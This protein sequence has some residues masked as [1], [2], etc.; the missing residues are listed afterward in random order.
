MAGLLRA[1]TAMFASIKCGLE[2][3]KPAGCHTAQED[4]TSTAASQS[5]SE[6]PSLPFGYVDAGSLSQSPV[7]SPTTPGVFNSLRTPPQLTE[8]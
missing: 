8:N 2:Q 3:T 6:L 1:S 4:L 7:A 5:I